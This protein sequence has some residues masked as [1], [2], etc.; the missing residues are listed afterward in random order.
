M[1]CGL[2]VTRKVPIKKKSL[3]IDHRPLLLPE[4]LPF[5]EFVSLSPG[6]VLY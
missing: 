6:F 5:G 2:K 3:S 4:I 1:C